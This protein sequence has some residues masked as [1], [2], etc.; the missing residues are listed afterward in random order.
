MLKNMDRLVYT[1]TILFHPDISIDMVLDLIES[2]IKGR[3]LKEVG[4]IFKGGDDD[5]DAGEL[6]HDMQT[7]EE[8]AE[9]STSPSNASPF[10]CFSF[11]FV[12]LFGPPCI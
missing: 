9:G 12:D 7:V 6:N 5:N 1:V 10:R 4:P 11:G 8:N 3:L 2:K